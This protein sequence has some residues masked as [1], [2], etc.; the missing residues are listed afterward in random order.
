MMA[1]ILDYLDKHFEEQ[2]SLECLAE[3]AG[4]SPHYL[5]REF[6][7]WVG[8]SPKQYIQ[9]LSLTR[10][11][12][13]LSQG[14]GVLEASVSSGLS[15]PGRLHDLFVTFDAVTPGQFKAK[16]A[17][18]QV[19]WGVAASP[20]GPAFIATSERGI[21]SLEFLGRFS[22]EETL[23][24]VE[25]QW[26][27]GRFQRNDIRATT[28]AE[29]VF[30]R[31]ASRGPIHL[32]LR[33]TNFRIKVWQALL[34]VPVGHLASYG[35]IA[36]AAGAPMAHRAVGNALGSNPIGWLIP[37]HRVIQANG[38]LGLYH[39]GLARKRS[40]IAWEQALDPNRVDSKTN[41]RISD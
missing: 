28:L 27:D 20:F 3:V 18:L 24:Q 17:S 4:Y 7:R 30:S 2:P 31:T 26:P 1:S 22:L 33:G 25:E 37:C 8:I 32:H 9:Q 6:S 16:G 12:E 41:A 14:K 39:W 15:G 23:A 40:M 34:K 19:E 10:A 38:K 21:L 29:K 5:Q 11:K 13:L 35:D 36:K